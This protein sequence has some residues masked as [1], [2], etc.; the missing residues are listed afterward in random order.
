MTGESLLEAMNATLSKDERLRIDYDYEKFKE[1]F[2]REMEK[3][4]GGN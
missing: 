1:E 2:N 4:E 3:L